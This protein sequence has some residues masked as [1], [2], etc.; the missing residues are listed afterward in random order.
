MISLGL[1][2]SGASQV[3]KFLRD[4]ERDVHKATTRAL[5]KVAAKGKTIVV[6]EIAGDIGTAIGTVKK[7]IRLTRAKPSHQVAALRAS[8][9]RIP[10]IKLRA[11][12]VRKGVSF[13]AGKGKGRKLV[14]GGFVATMRSGHKGTYKRTSK[15][16]LP[17]TE[18]HG[19]SVP[20]VFIKGRTKLLVDRLVD[21]EFRIIF[22]REYRFLRR[23]HRG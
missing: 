4:A 13:S 21:T 14:P 17:I 10:L 16:R 6:R 11:R 1:K 15:R 8:G 22:D 2:V 23:R 5:N 9:R 20:Q 19:P 3:K 18:L 12:Q 7:E